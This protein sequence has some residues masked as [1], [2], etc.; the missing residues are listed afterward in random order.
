[1]YFSNLKNSFLQITPYEA[2][3]RELKFVIDLRQTTKPVGKG[4]EERS[5]S[6]HSSSQSSKS[7]RSMKSAFSKESMKTSKSEKLD[8]V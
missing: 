7:S 5:N 2:L 6:S 8:S 3:M 4:L 1:M